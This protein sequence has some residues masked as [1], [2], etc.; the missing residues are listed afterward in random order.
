[1]SK[2]SVLENHLVILCFPACEK[3]RHVMAVFELGDKFSAMVWWILFWRQPHVAGP[4]SSSSS[5]QAT[6]V[7]SLSD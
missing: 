2:G 4:S 3:C 6:D 7:L 1:M 5:V